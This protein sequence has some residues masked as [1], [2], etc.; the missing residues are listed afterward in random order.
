MNLG[1]LGKKKPGLDDWLN[2]DG[3]KMGE[4]RMTSWVHGLRIWVDDGPFTS[5]WHPG[6]GPYLLNIYSLMAQTEALGCHIISLSL[7]FK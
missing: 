4:S 3:K 7:L 2:M 5:L 6:E 1:A